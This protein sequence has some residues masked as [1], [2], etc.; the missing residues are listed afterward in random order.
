M[1]LLCSI[2]ICQSLV[3]IL[4]VSSNSRILYCYWVDTDFTIFFLLPAW[5]QNTSTRQRQHT[6]RINIMLQCWY[7][8]DMTEEKITAAFKPTHKHCENIKHLYFPQKKSLACVYVCVLN[9]WYILFFNCLKNIPII[10]YSSSDHEL[11]IGLI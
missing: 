1:D 3:D 8:T 7:T 6:T 2:H 10:I 9:C 11:I 4:D 5:T